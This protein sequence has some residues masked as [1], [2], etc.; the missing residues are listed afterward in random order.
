MCG[1]DRSSVA[2]F[3]VQ[4]S[5]SNCPCRSRSLHEPY[6]QMT[7]VA[8]MVPEAKECGAKLLRLCLQI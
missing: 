3:Q 7:E 1:P 6:N 8:A 2:T 5:D 4:V